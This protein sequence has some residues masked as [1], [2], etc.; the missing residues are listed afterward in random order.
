LIAIIQITQVV[1]VFI[2]GPRLILGI[3]EHH[4]N[5]IANPDEGSSMVSIVFQ[6]RVQI[7]TGSGV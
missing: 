4:A 6:E 3:R 2:L 7:S 1:Q 5:L